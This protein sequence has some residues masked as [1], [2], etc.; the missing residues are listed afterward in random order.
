MLPIPIISTEI[1]AS[2]AEATQIGAL[3][4]I[5][6]NRNRF[7]TH[8]IISLRHL[9]PGRETVRV[10]SPIGLLNLRNEATSPASSEDTIDGSVN[11]AKV[12]P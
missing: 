5:D 7:I 11:G 1:W 6:A 8:Q 4:M 3:K 12:S 9:S 2:C 10:I